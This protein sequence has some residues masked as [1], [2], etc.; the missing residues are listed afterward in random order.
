MIHYP[1]PPHHQPAY[2][3]WSGL[4]RPVTEKIHRE[5]MSLPMGPHLSLEQAGT[6]AEVINRWRG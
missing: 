3:A 4:A 5:V 1:I 6:V 2:A